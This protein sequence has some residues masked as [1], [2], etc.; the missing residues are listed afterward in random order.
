MHSGGWDK[1]VVGARNQR[2]NAWYRRLWAYRN[3]SLYT[4]KAMGMNVIYHDIVDVLPLGNATAARS[5]EDPVT[6]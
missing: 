6:L 2:P 1:S 4:R 3:P 5:L